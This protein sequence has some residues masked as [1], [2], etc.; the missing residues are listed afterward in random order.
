MM[1]NL[2]SKNMQEWYLL[3]K[4]RIKQGD[5]SKHEIDKMIKYALKYGDPK[6]I[7]KIKKKY[8]NMKSKKRKNFIPTL[9]PINE[10]ILF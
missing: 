10:N 2:E 9:Q 3:N 4:E 6:K 7:N 5:L 8:K 1:A